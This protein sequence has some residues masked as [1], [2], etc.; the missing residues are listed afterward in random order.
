MLTTVSSAVRRR[1]ATMLERRALAGSVAELAARGWEHLADPIRQVSLPRRA[2]VVGVGG[3]SLGGSCKTPVVIELARQLAQRGVSVAVVGHGFRGRGG[4]GPARRVAKDDLAARVGDDAVLCARELESCGVPVFF[5]DR[6][7]ALALAASVARVV[8]LDGVLQTRP[9]RLSLGLLVADEPSALDAPCP[10]AGDR[11]AARDRLLAA[12]DVVVLGQEHPVGADL[13]G[14]QSSSFASYVTGIRCGDTVAP[15]S[16][17]VGRRVGLS[18]AVARPHRVVR[19]VHAAGIR[20]VWTELSP[21][22]DRPRR[23]RHAVDAWL[24]TAKCA[25]KLDERR[26]IPD[27]AVLDHRVRLP[28]ALVDRVAILAGAPW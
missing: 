27:L 10:P 11:R 3:P 5:G 17:L 21:D 9:E 13:A 7:Q 12:A 20:P 23:G 2:V 22:H 4:A 28:A 24:M 14:R 19:A 26:A 25:T 18:L 15:L 6:T 8:V 16:A 1:V